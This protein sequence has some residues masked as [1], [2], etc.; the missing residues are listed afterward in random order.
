MRV[1]DIPRKVHLLKVKSI[2]AAEPSYDDVDESNSTFKEY[3]KIVF[4]SHAWE[5]GARDDIIHYNEARDRQMIYKLQIN[6]TAPLASKLM[7]QKLVTV[8]WDC[9]AEDG[10]KQPILGF[11]FATG[12]MKMWSS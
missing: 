10:I 8:Y 5:P 7:I 1:I 11:E 9:F 2:Y 6:A 12:L 3:R 4:C